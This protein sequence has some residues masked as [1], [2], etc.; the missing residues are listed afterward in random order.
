M[1]QCRLCQKEAKL[2]NSH[3]IPKAAYKF[4]RDAPSKGGKGPV[5]I[6]TR[7]G[8]A[9]YNEKQVTSYLLC[10]S[11]EDRFSKKGE[12][13]VGT[14]WATH[15]GFPLLKKLSMHALIVAG[16]RFAIYD[17]LKVDKMIREALLY[18]AISVFWRAHVWDWGKQTDSYKKALGTHYESTFRKFLLGEGGLPNAK[19]FLIVNGSET[20]NGLISMPYAGKVDGCHI[21][22]FDLLGIKFSLVVGKRLPAKLAAA[23]A[24]FS[25]D[26]VFVS[27]DFESSP[28]FLQMAKTV[29]TTVTPR[30]RLAQTEPDFGM[31]VVTR[32]P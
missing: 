2:I 15:S 18:F 14:L 22:N 1:Q 19:L 4:V 29:Q 17:P 16:S 9:N 25:S 26:V 20:L 10:R 23:F 28:D 11:C 21:H 8:A 3:L 7:E 5:K 12:R 31:G 6:D 13:V 32:L 24:Q 27:A 30:G